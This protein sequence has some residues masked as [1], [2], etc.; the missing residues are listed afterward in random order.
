VFPVAVAAA[1]GWLFLFIVLLAVPPSAAPVPL[2]PD[3]GDEPPAVLSQLTSK[4]GELGF[5]AT[6]IDLAVRGWFQ[7][8]TPWG[9][10]APARCVVPAETPG[11]PLTPFERRA[12]AH[13]A[14]RAG[15]RGEV[16]A[17]A[18][19]DGFEGGEDPFMSAFREEVDAETRRRG[20]TRPRLSGRRIGLLCLLAFIPAGALA[21]ALALAHVKYPAGWG[22]GA[23][24]GLCLVALFT[25]ASRKPS[26]AGRAALK[27]WS[28]AVEAAPGDGGLLGYAAALGRAPG[29]VAVFGPPG[30]NTVWSGYRG[31][32]QQLEIE[33]D[34]WSWP[35]GLAI[36]LAIILGV[37]FGPVA[38]IGGVFWLF[39]H[40]LGSLGKLVIELTVAT[41]IAAVGLRLA[42]RALFPRY[43]EF[44]GQVVRQ[45]KVEGDSETPD[46]HHVAVDDGTRDKAWDFTVGA[47]P[48]RQL[49]PGTFVHV[50]V[51]LDSR[52][53]VGARLKELVRKS[54]EA[55]TVFVR[56]D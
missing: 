47:E 10:T 24:F 44:D 45:W 19:A 56:C 26:A 12:V 3:S 15:A 39:S 27:R 36:M 34:T 18:L 53:E 48:Y 8:S 29:A 43:A 11:G 40:G 23:W 49:T 50:R 21:A 4:L 55:G 6:L 38:Y 46:R 9:P 25:G 22:G 7:V 5:R 37:S 2:P 20:L 31:S 14:L 16:P 52:S 41:V 51:N 30:K 32:W 1:A 42:R 28:S 54:G 33:R 17:P 35:K 13:V